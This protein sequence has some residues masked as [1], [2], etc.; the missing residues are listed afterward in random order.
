MR[1]SVL[2]IG[3]FALLGCSGNDPGFL[4]SSENI[5]TQDLYVYLSANVHT[6]WGEQDAPDE[7]Y[8]TLQVKMYGYDAGA[9]FYNVELAEADQLEATVNDTTLPLNAVALRLDAHKLC[10]VYTADFDTTSAAALYTVSFNRGKETSPHNIEVTLL[11]ETTFSLSPAETSIELT[12]TVTPDWDRIEE[13]DYRL[14][15]LLRCE[16]TNG[17]YHWSGVQFPNNRV[18][19]ISSPFAFNPSNFFN[20]PSA[21]EY[22]ACELLTSLVSHQEQEAPADSDFAEVAIHTTREQHAEKSIVLA[23]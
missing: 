21:S 5:S 20:Q 19:E 17:A 1:H 13:Y 4:R 15:F 8:T 11:E 3:L 18:T 9:Y 22:T 23:Q 16:D 2:A 12:D 14:E 7:T 10:V 6:L